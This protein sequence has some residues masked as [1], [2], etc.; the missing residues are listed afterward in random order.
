MKNVII[1]DDSM[2]SRMIIRRCLDMIGF[3]GVLYHEAKDGAEA[4]D[5]AIGLPGGSGPDLMIADLNMPNMDGE[6]LLA[7]LKESESTRNTPVLIASS[8]TNA[9]RMEKLAAMGVL[10]TI[11]KPVSPAT[12]QKALGPVLERFQGKD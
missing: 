4:L 10:G 2:T 12:L 3:T 1:V 5:L 9:A 7:K 6:T 8:A 11:G